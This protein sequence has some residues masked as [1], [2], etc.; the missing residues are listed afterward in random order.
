[1]LFVSSIS[2]SAAFPL[3]T[4]TPPMAMTLGAPRLVQPQIIP[5]LSETEEI[6]VNSRLQLFLKPLTRLHIVVTLPEI[7]LSAMSVSNW[8]IMEKLKTLVKPEPF[9][10]LNVVN[11]SRESV[12]LE[13]EFSSVKAMRRSIPLLS[14]QRFKHSNFTDLL[15]I[16]IVTFDT[17]APVK[18]EWEAIFRDKGMISFQTSPPGDRPD[19]IRLENL[20]IAWFSETV[21]PINNR[22]IPSTKIL[23]EAFERFG[24]IRRVEII[25]DAPPSEDGANF[26]SFGPGHTQNQNM[27]AYIQYFDYQSFCNSMEGLRDR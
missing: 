21:D 25:A 23:R 24:G 15:S 9:E 2:M 11:L 17:V 27:T 14:G 6:L 8:E 7:K 18:T 1:M 3:P 4:L 12:T 20:P 22:L 16:K 10:F 13:A 26:N 19:T 5:T